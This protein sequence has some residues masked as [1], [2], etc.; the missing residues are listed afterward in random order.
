MTAP[1]LLTFRR[2]VL[3]PQAPPPTTAVA[4]STPNT[5]EPP[6]SYPIGTT[7]VDIRAILR[8]IQAGRALTIPTQFGDHQTVVQDQWVKQGI[9]TDG[10]A[11]TKEGLL[12][13]AITIPRPD[14]ATR[15]VEFLLIVPLAADGTT[16]PDLMKGASVVDASFDAGTRLLIGGIALSEPE[17]G[18]T[19]VFHYTAYN[20]ETQ[21]YEARM[22]W[23]TS[24]PTPVGGDLE[25]ST[26][27]IYAM[28]L[29]ADAFREAVD[30]TTVVNRVDERLAPEQ[31]L[32]EQA[33][34]KVWSEM[35]RPLYGT[36]RALRTDDRWTAAIAARDP[37]ALDLLRVFSVRADNDLRL[38]DPDRAARLARH[39]TIEERFNARMKTFQ[40]NG[41]FLNRGEVF[42]QLRA[43]PDPAQREALYRQ[44]LTHYGDLYREPDHLFASADFFNAIAARYGLGNYADM[45]YRDRFGF[46]AREFFAL[47]EQYFKDTDADARAYVAMLRQAQTRL[48][49]KAGDTVHI[50]DVEFLDET[51][52]QQFGGVTAEPRLTAAQAL[53]A[54]KAF[55][56]E[57]GIDLDAAP[58]NGIVLDAA[59]R[60][61]KQG[62][63]GEALPVDKDLSYI[64][65]NLDDRGVSLDE[66]GT[67]IH[68]Y[69]HGIHFQAAQ[70]RAGSYLA[71][72]DLWGGPQDFPEGIAMA[73][74]RLINNPEIAT[75]ILGAYPGF[76]RAYLETRA[77]VQRVAET[78]QTR[79]YFM[80]A[81]QEILLYRT[82]H[83]DGSPW[84]LEARLAQWNRWAREVLFV[85]PPAGLVYGEWAAK[86]HLSGKDYYLYYG[87]YPAGAI[88]AERVVEK[89]VR[90]GTAQELR[91]L[92]DPMLALLRRGSMI[93]S[94]DI[95]R[96]AE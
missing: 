9:E 43:E 55:Y 67:L 39:T 45:V 40:W 37:R 59:K 38:S 80:I 31:P 22:A 83:D 62:T 57:I 42:K 10:N 3:N 4:R 30:A 64:I 69:V 70:Q 18:T 7:G 35:L 16:S 24:E 27:L 81:M 58:W 88:R 13:R 12:L 50:H 78:W 56:A 96:A 60:P 54:V 29:C 17:D 15:R 44:F 8:D 95:R 26:R 49:P 66:L 28:A 33:E 71:V 92:R 11:A 79:K 84:P 85:E 1:D 72:K 90:R 23:I 25:Q 36:L 86:P 94:D 5:A 14:G 61:N 63:L 19:T 51:W 52:T 68:E 48:H 47:A 65:M 77:K 75:R 91:S 82:T 41:A 32:L 89:Y 6:R 87:G 20:A 46:D 76:T 34:A 73:L 21:Q 53:A 93:T 74:Q 2:E